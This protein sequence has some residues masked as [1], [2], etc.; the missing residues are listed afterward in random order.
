MLQNNGGSNLKKKIRFISLILV[1]VLSFTLLAGCGKDSSEDVVATINDEDIS[2]TEAMYY[3][4]IVES[5]YSMFLSADAW[6]MLVEG[7]KTFS[8]LTKEYVMDGIVESN[9]LYDLGK[10]AGIEITEDM[11][12]QLKASAVQY[13]NSLS[14]E[15][16]EATGLDEQSLYD[17]S[18]KSYISSEHQATILNALDI[19]IEGISA[20]Y[21]QEELRQYN[22]EYLH[23]PFISI[24]EEGNQVEL[25]E[26]EK[27]TAKETL[28]NMLAE[29][30]DG[31]TFE[32]VIEGN[33]EIQTNTANFV[34]GYD[35]VEL[36]YEE[37]AAEL[38]N[39]AIAGEI[40]ETSAGYYIIKMVD[41]NSSEYY[42]SA[43]NTALSEKQQELY[44]EKIEELKAD[45][46][47]V[48]NEDVWEPIKVGR[49]TINLDYDEDATSVDGSEDVDEVDDTEEADKTDD[50]GDVD[51]TDDAKE[52][53]NADELSED[54]DETEEDNK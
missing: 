43:V 50:S 41:N 18:V 6:D 17:I 44:A 30:Q 5:N 7:D 38:E 1:M 28:E 31:K 34:P 13:F 39:D 9:I 40:V 24:D 26:E 22:T 27:S 19:D 16:V 14:E 37:V 11:E 12:T 35:Q 49:T 21:D 29:V 42:E 36:A 46:T 33:E 15:Q 2:L 20:E 32:E 10:E 52:T 54:T 51:E 3:I 47:I 48:I 45:Y 4:S 23:I 25:T 53:D 8:D